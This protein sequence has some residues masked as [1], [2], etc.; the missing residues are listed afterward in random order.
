MSCVLMSQSSAGKSVLAETVEKMTPP[1]DVVLLSRLTTNGLF[2]MRRDA[3]KRKLVIVEE[4]YGSEAADYSIRALQSRKKLI[5]AAPVKD[6]QTGN[7]KTKVFTVEAR[8]AFIEAT[9]RPRSTTRTRRAASS[10]R[11]TRAPSR[12]GA[13]TSA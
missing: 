13:S 9:T 6:P 7:I 11:W 12:R 4:R 1:E 10:W 8:A 2:Y 5:P 3:L